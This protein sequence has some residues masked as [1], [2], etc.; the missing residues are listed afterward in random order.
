MKKEIIDYFIDI[1]VSKKLI[2]NEEGNLK[3]NKI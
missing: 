1:L 3:K 2:D